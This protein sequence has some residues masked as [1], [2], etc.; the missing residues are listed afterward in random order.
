MR[1]EFTA[2]LKNSLE[3]AQDAARGLNQDFVSTEHL[4]LG[5]MDVPESEAVAGLKLAEVD[6]PELR[7]RLTTSLPRGAAPPVVTGNLPLSPKAK[8]V[9]NT[10]LVRAQT[11]GQSRVSSRL[12]LASLLDECETVVREAM[13]DSGA[14]IDHLQRVLMQDGA[15]SAEE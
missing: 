8:R 4:L 1:E 9:I 10:S 3:K 13:R 5:L 12:L 14:D 2:G 15:I 6:L 11:S 7:E